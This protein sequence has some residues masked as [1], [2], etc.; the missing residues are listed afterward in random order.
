MVTVHLLRRVEF[1]D[2]AAC[3]VKSKTLKLRKQSHRVTCKRCLRIADGEKGHPWLVF[4]GTSCALVWA[5]TKSAA[6]DAWRIEWGRQHRRRIEP[7]R[8][9]VKCRRLRLSDEGWIRQS[10]IE[11]ETRE[12]PWSKALNTLRVRERRRAA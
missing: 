2:V 1:H 11:T 5:R 4:C 3:G 10:V 7:I 6:L 8:A 9:E 12:S